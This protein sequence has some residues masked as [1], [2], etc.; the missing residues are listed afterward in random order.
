MATDCN[1]QP[2]PIR[3]LNPHEGIVVVS[4]I[5]ALSG[6]QKPA[7][8][9]LQAEANSWEVALCTGFIPQP[10]AWMALQ[11]VIWPSLQYPLAV[12]SFSMTRALSATSLLYCTLL[13]CLGVNQCYPLALHH[14]PVKFHGLGLPHPFWEQGIATLNLFLEFRNTSHPEQSLLQTSLEYLQL[15]IGIRSQH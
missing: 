5:Q 4:I 11:R 10:L 14:A 3:Q 1:H 15:E 12:P 2:Q 13:P 7:L 8:M 6:T 9:A